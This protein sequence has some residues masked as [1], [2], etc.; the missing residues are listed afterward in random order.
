MSPVIDPQ[1]T[2]PARGTR[3]AVTPVSLVVGGSAAPLP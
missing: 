1:C 2:D 3:T